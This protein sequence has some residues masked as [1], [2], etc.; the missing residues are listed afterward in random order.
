MG[1]N[2][3]VSQALQVLIVFLL[4]IALFAADPPPPK[5]K[6]VPPPPAAKVAQPKGAK[7]Q[8]K[9]QQVQ[10]ANKEAR[11]AQQALNAQNLPA[12]MTLQR[13]SE[14]SPEER[15]KALSNLPPQRQAN[16]EKRVQAYANQPPEQKAREQA[17]ESRLAALPA[18]RQAQV[19]QSLLDLSSIQGPRRPVIMNE[20]NRQ[21]S[22]TDAQRANYINSKGFLSRFSPQEVELMNNLHGVVP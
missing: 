3:R 15:A 10:N 21:S 17:Q 11:A 12:G 5:P 8:E 16:I 4:P 2:P 18:W 19:R 14:M 7:F 13:L 1:T 9:K 6:P 22:M 20:L